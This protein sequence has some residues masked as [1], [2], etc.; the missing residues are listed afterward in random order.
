MVH[1]VQ[2]GQVVLYH[3]LVPLALMVQEVLMVL[4]GQTLQVDLSLLLVQR[5]QLVQDVLLVLM[6]PEVQLHQ[7]IL[8]GQ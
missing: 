4:M 3:P 8:A 2:M 1:W 6:G 7:L 5:A